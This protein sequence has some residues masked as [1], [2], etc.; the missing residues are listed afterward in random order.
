MTQNEYNHYIIDQKV[1]II[2]YKLIKDQVN[3]VSFVL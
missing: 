1:K 3:E 2:K